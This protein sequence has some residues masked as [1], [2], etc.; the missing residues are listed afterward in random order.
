MLDAEGEL[1]FSIDRFLFMTTMQIRWI[2][3]LELNIRS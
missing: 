3:S 2:R 1:F